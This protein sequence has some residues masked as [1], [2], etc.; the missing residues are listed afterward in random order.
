MKTTAQKA[1]WTALK[2]GIN[3]TH[4]KEDHLQ[5]EYAVIDPRNG[6]AIV[7]LR[8]YWTGGSRWYACLWILDGAS[9]TYGNGSGYAGGYGYCKQSAAAAAAID[10]AGIELAQSIA[11]VGTE[12]IREAL[13][14]IAAKLHPRRK[15][16]LHHAH[17]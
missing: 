9:R 11:G 16:I 14:A 15:M 5:H 10:A 13:L 4:R 8:L 6:A 3:R 7:T 17:G 1:I 2:D 12:A